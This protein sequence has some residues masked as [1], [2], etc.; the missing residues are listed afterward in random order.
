[1]QDNLLSS[2][3]RFLSDFNIGTLLVG[4]SGDDVVGVD[5]T[6]EPTEQ[7]QENGDD[8]FGTAKPPLDDDGNRRHYR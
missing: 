8:G 5:H 1:M 2:T 3:V 7:A 4:I 6:G